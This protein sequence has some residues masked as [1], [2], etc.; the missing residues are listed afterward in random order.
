H[1]APTAL[2]WRVL[3]SILVEQRTL[4]PTLTY[5]SDDMTTNVILAAANNSANCIFTP[6]CRVLLRRTCRVLR[7]TSTMSFVVRALA[8]RDR[9]APARGSGHRSAIAHSTIEFLPR[10]AGNDA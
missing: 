1:R 5:R 10:A 7:L 4:A 9:C 2:Q 6:P 3:A 8:K